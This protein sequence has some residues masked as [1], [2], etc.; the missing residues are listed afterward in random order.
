[1]QA[2]AL[3]ERIDSRMTAGLRVTRDFAVLPHRH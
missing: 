2:S 1:M 3:I